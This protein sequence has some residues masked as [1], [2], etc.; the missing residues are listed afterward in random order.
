ML[1]RAFVSPLLALFA[2]QTAAGQQ[3][4]LSGPLSGFLFDSPTS[5]IRPII[6]IAGSAYLGAPIL[7]G[8][9]FASVGPNGA[10]ALVILGGQLSAVSGLNS[11]APQI[12]PLDAPFSTS[13]I[14]G[15]AQ[16]GS[17]VV[18]ASGSGG[19][20]IQSVR[21]TGG[22]PSLDPAIDLSSIGG[23]ISALAVDAALQK[24]LIGIRADA[25][26]GVY[27]WDQNGS[28]TMLTP[29]A[30]PSALALNSDGAMA[31]ATDRHSGL[32]VRFAVGAVPSPQPVLQN[33]DALSEPVGVLL[34]SDGKTVY[35][36]DR[37]KGVLACD[38]DSQVCSSIATDV[39]PKGFMLLAQSSV[40]LVSDRQT[41]TDPVVVFDS[42][43]ASI[44]FVPGGS[45]Q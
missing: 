6:G 26:G 32:V 45:A 28:P 42:G 16:D 33:S 12:T 40:F 3:A 8:L 14:I 4:T 23:T 21:W 41:P 34:S 31:I 20:V 39:V 35:I 10:N 25:A 36:A 29:M 15:W 27:L 18:F 9:D 17:Q 30:D 19:A 11:T 44:Y 7:S 38:V 43:S 5:S 22:L 2:I 24:I 13:M 1:F 37:G